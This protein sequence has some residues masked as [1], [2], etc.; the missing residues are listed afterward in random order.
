MTARSLMFALLLGSST[1]V[2]S[3]GMVSAIRDRTPT[4]SKSAQSSPIAIG[5]T[6][7]RGNFSG[8][9]LIAQ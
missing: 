9:A 8:L 3:D 4:S 1:P 6:D 5:L 2:S 7:S